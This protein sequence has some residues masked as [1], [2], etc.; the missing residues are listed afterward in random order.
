MSMPHGMLHCEPARVAGVTQADGLAAES[1]KQVPSAIQE[2]I[3]A[4]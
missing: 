3:L 4:T 1:R 2:R